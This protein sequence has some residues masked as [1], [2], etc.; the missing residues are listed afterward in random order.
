MEDPTNKEV[1]FAKTVRWMAQKYL[2]FNFF[3]D[4][5]TQKYFQFINPNVT[6]PQRNA[7]RALVMKTYN[8]VKQS[9]IQDL[10]DNESKISFTVDGWTSINGK[11]Y[12]GVTAHFIDKKW[13][14]ISVALDFIP[15][16]GKHTGRDIAQMF[17]TS[18]KTHGILE[19]I[20]GVTLDN[21]SS[22]TTFMQQF[23]KIMEE[24]SLNFDSENQH[25]HCFAH[26]L[27]LAVQDALKHLYADCNEY[28]DNEEEMDDNKDDNAIIKLRSLF[29]KLKKSEQLQIQLKSCCDVT[30]TT[31]S[32]PIVDVSTR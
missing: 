32:S 2:P 27:N 24:D 16:N 7:L 1:F 22:N 29:L 19:K 18:L 28:I 17:Y 13:Q 14:F 26:I 21:A 4:L 10:R 30:D 20:Q 11:S 5:E 31:Y 15:S 25:F 12:Y 8:D 6:V 3:D 23:S 9:V